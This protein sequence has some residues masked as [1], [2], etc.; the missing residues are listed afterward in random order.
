MTHV[1]VRE[2]LD[3][4]LTGQ[5]FVATLPCTYAMDVYTE[6]IPRINPFIWQYASAAAHYISFR[7]TEGMQIDEAVEWLNGNAVMTP[8]Q[9]YIHN[10]AYMWC[11]WCIFM[12]IYTYIHIY[13]AVFSAFK[14]HGAYI[15]TW[16]G[17]WLFHPEGHDHHQER[18]IPLIYST[19]SI[20]KGFCNH[21]AYTSKPYIQHVRRQRGNSSHE[22]WSLF[23][24]DSWAP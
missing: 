9:T 23:P 21:R 17:T 14:R 10:F 3:F 24:Y 20:S 18:P 22:H 13:I 12:Y 4:M 7:L 19:R 16:G 15:Y 5:M 8:I 1:H 2:I 11:R 6:H